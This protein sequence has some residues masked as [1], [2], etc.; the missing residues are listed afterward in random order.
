LTSQEFPNVFTIAIY[1]YL[2]IIWMMLKPSPG[3]RQIAGHAYFF[4]APPTLIA[5]DCRGTFATLLW[6]RLMPS[7]I[8]SKIALFRKKSVA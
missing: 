6:Q 3:G 4:I 5:R 2:I 8:R 1:R 7:Q